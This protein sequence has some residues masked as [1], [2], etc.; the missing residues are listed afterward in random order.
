LSPADA[1]LIGSIQQVSKII[2]Q[3]KDLAFG[4]TDP[5]GNVR[6]GIFTSEDDLISRGKHGIFLA[7]ERASGTPLGVSVNEYQD[8]VQGMIRVLLELA[9]ESGGRFTDKDV[10][11]IQ[12]QVANV[13]GI[14]G[15][16]PEGKLEAEGKMGR[17]E[18]LLIDK[19]GFLHSPQM[20]QMGSTKKPTK[21]WNPKTKKLEVIK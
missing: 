16:M 2:S 1:K 5:K 18:D 11:Q 3:L 4:F 15:L 6:P 17:M 9:G 21:R 7:K 8:A 20:I 13:A 19:L 14:G 10:E 12:K